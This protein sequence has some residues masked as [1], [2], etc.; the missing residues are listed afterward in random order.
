MDVRLCKHC[1]TH[2]EFYPSR[3][4]K[5]KV[6]L[7]KSAYAWKERNKE[8]WLEIVRESKLRTY[9]DQREKIL[10]KNAEWRK[11]NPEYVRKWAKDH[12]EVFA[13]QRKLRELC[14][15]QRT[16]SWACVEK[17]NEIYKQARALGMEVDH[18]IPLQG[19]TVSGLHVENNLQ[20]LTKKENRKKS[21][22]YECDDFICSD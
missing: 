20:L 8:R 7:R 22:K 5:C 9:P 16:P 12:P 14:V 15:K 17:M 19:K 1:E 4:S 10:S 18:I 21:N 6:C 3:P 13:R 11:N 2:Q